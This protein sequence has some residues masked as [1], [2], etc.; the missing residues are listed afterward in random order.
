MSEVNDQHRILDLIR[1]ARTIE[2]AQGVVLEYLEAEGYGEVLY[3]L[4][5]RILQI[6]REEG[7]I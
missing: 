6:L 3:Q 5:R 2:E 1:Q 7:K 4:G